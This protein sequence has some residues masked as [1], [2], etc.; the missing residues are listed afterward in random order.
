MEEQTSARQISIRQNRKDP[1]ACRSI[2]SIP[3]TCW[4]R[5][6]L[7]VFK[8]LHVVAR[9]FGCLRGKWRKNVGEKTEEGKSRRWTLVRWWNKEKV[10]E[11]TG[12]MFLYEETRTNGGGGGGMKNVER[13]IAFKYFNRNKSSVLPESS[14]QP[15]NTL[16]ILCL[17]LLFRV[18]S[19]Q[20]VFHLNNH[21]TYQ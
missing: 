2:S 21:T 5:A 10:E 7:G 19:L 11:E 12:K 17:P 8:T 15:C 3:W 20:G 4:I 18:V 6:S 16:S 13:Y 1:Q 14:T 9:A